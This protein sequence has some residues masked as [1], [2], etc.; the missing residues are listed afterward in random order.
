MSPKWW[1]AGLLCMVAAVSG[2][3]GEQSAGALPSA[4]VEQV[5]AAKVTTTIVGSA[6]AGRTVF[7]TKCQICHK[8]DDTEVGT[9]P[10]LVN[11]N[12]TADAIRRQVQHPRDAMPP[13]LVS[14]TDLDDVSAFIL[15]LR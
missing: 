10:N 14:G 3:G 11:A 9:G 5:D 4:P 6:A 13:N 8:L 15:Q 1:I 7:E 12:L 2:C